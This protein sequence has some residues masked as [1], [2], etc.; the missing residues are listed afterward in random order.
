MELV[1]SGPE[2]V[3]SCGRVSDRSQALAR[4]VLLAR[5]KTRYLE[6]LVGSIMLAGDEQAAS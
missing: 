1:P 6:L 5:E 4:G 3:G 2:L